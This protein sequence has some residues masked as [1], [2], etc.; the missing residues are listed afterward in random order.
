MA[1]VVPDTRLLPSLLRVTPSAVSE[2][3]SELIGCPISR[4]LTT[5]CV[6]LELR[7]IPSTGIPAASPTPLSQPP[8]LP[9]KRFS[10]RRHPRDGVICHLESVFC[11]HSSPLRGWWGRRERDMAAT[12]VAAANEDHRSFSSPIGAGSTPVLP[13]PDNSCA[14]DIVRKFVDGCT[15]LEHAGF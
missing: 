6:C 15:K 12:H 9:E 8:Q 5:Y 14:A 3:S 10:A 11:E 13:N 7:S 2:H 4:S 1:S